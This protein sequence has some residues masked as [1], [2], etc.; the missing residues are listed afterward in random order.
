MINLVAGQGQ[1]SAPAATQGGGR[2][3]RG[4]T[5]PL[6]SQPAPRLPDGTVNLGR[7]PGELG[8]WQL[9]YSQSMGARN[10]VVG[11]PAA[12]AG[13]RGEGRGGR[14]GG[15]IGGGEG[16]GGGGQRGGATTEPWIP[17]QPWAAAF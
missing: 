11:A 9:P 4:T 10:I 8:I 3:A 13:A 14:G 7:V 5:N 12:P 1:R 6:L 2:G 15:Q 16:A 17:F